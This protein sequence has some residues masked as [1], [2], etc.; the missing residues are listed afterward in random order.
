MTVTIHAPSDVHE[1]IDEGVRVSTDAEYSVDVVE[2]PGE[3]GRASAFADFEAR[4]DG[5]E[6]DY[7]N[8][9]FAGCMAAIGE[10][11]LVVRLLEHGR[12]DLAARVLYW[13]VACRTAQ[14]RTAEA[15]GHAA[16]LVV[17]GLRLPSGA[18][19]AT[20]EAEAIFDDAFR[21]SQDTPRAQLG[22]RSSVR[23]THVGVDGRRRVC[24]VPCGVE[25]LPGEHVI[26]FEADGHESLTQ[27]TRL[28]SEP[29]LVEIELHRA[30]ADEAGRQWAERYRGLA[31]MASGPSLRL[32][33]QA[34]A[35]RR[36]AF[37]RGEE[38]GSQIRLRAAL[39]VDGEYREE[40][41]RVIGRDELRLAAGEVFEDLLIEGNLV[42]RP[43]YTRVGFWIGVGIAVVA[44][45]ATTAFLLYERDTEYALRFAPPRTP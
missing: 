42:S 38:D 44:G 5:A 19:G 39:A 7:I 13:R 43:F 25:L 4:L 15:R 2:L 33:S 36:L 21:E 12:R 18:V 11:E 17:F 6:R 20:P 34:F 8:A 28:S 9:D 3:Q 37:L 27:V 10:E 22:F 24:Q 35:T 29:M 40:I 41:E 14:L 30:S 1:T 16:R 26:V 31:A 23:G 32:L 45:A